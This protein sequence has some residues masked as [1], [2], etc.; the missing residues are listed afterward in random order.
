MPPTLVSE[1]NAITEQDLSTVVIPRISNPTLE[2][3]LME[4]INDET[5]TMGMSSIVAYGKV[6]YSKVPYSKVPYRKV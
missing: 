5:G 3:L 6:A 2:R 1:S 4:V